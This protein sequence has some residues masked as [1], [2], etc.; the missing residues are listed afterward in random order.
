MKHNKTKSP[1][2]PQSTNPLHFAMATNEVL[3]M[4]SAPADDGQFE[5]LLLL[6]VRALLFETPFRNRRRS[7][8]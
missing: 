2:L 8:I 7:Y 3:C 1:Q 5:I 6:S 4:A